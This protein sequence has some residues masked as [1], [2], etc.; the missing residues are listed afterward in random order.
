M[1]WAAI[2]IGIIIIVAAGIYLSC[3]RVNSF[4]RTATECDSCEF[5][6]DNDRVQGKIIGSDPD[7][8]AIFYGGNTYLRSRDEIYPV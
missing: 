7:E 3:H 1:T 8:V 6:I 4:Q 5:Y 2:I